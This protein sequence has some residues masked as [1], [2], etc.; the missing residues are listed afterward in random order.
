MELVNNGLG[1]VIS[2]TFA[3]HWFIRYL[4]LHFSEQT[5]GFRTDTNEVLSIQ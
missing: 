3:L 1:T 2:K 5:V 4:N